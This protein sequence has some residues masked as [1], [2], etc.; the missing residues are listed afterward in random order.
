MRDLR[1]S[2]FPNASISL[3]LGCRQQCIYFIRCGGT[4]EVF[5]R[6]DFPREHSVGVGSMLANLLGRVLRNEPGEKKKKSSYAEHRE[7]DVSPFQGRPRPTPRGS[8]RMFS[9][10]VRPSQMSTSEAEQ[11]LALTVCWTLLC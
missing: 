2:I 11:A 5:G 1:D 7:R 9:S 8:P 10:C 4:K 6:V 3:C